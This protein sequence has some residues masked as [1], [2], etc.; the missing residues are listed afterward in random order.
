M[1][2]EGKTRRP[3]L[4]HWLLL[5]CHTHTKVESEEARIDIFNSDVENCTKSEYLMRKPVST[6]HRY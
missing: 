1:R 4:P 2:W 5:P 3:F 6:I